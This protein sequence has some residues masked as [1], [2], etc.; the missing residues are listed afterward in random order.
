MKT[1]IELKNEAKEVLKGRWKESIMLC[2]FPLLLRMAIT[3]LLFLLLII[4]MIT[5]I[6]HNPDFFQETH[7]MNLI[8]R[9]E[10]IAL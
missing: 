10:S 5:F 2:L 4:P 9:M 6:K 8:L 1:T 7:P 3:L